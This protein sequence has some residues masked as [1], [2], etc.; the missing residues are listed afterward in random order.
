MSLVAEANGAEVHCCDW[1]ELVPVVEAAGGCD[2]VI[3]DAPYSQKTHSGHDGGTDDANG[4]VQRPEVRG[5]LARYKLGLH[6]PLRRHLSYTP[7]GAGD[8]F[9]FVVRWAPITRGW[10]C[11]ITDDVLAPIWAQAF[12]SVN[13][14]AF[15]P[16]PFVAPGSRVRLTGDGPSAWTTWIVVAR[17]RTPEYVRWGTLPGAYVLP[18]GEGG[19]LPVVGGKPAWLLERLICDYTRPNDLAVDP[20][21][22]AGTLAVAAIRHGRRAIV[23][24]SKPEHA[25]LAAEW[26][27]NPHRKAPTL[28]EL[29]TPEGQGR[30]FG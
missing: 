4:V 28:R 6:Q 5:N 26:I 24:D 7:W 21:C 23:G 2:A 16:L 14:Y 8:V 29:R 19:A 15:A 9:A 30:L 20:C 25:E 17:P 10:F 12:E 13:R 11:S 22:G 27:R 18:E 3:V 1:R